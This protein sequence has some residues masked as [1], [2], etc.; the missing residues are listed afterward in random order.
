MVRQRVALE[1]EKVKVRRHQKELGHF[2]VGALRVS[3]EGVEVDRFYDP[4]RAGRAVSP[5][6]LLPF[7]LRLLQRRWPIS[8]AYELRQSCAVFA[9]LGGQPGL[10]R[11]DERLVWIDT[12][13][14][15]ILDPPDFEADRQEQRRKI[16][17]RLSGER[18]DCGRSLPRAMTPETAQGRIRV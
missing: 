12:D 2:L 16:R 17:Q 13:E 1:R 4:S 14:D 5:R 10:M 7:V 8:C 9:F 11:I 3:V 18:F 6:Q 15:L